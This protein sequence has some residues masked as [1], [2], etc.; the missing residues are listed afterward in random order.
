MDYNYYIFDLDGV[1]VDVTN[2]YKKEIMDKVGEKLN[3][4]F[5]E[6]QIKK[7]WYEI[8]GHRDSIIRSWGFN[9]EKFWNVFDSLDTP[10]KRIKNTFI[11][12]DTEAILK[13]K[14]KKMGVVT[15]SNFKVARETL[16]RNNIYRY[17]DTVI[18]CNQEIGY[19]PNPN[20]V[21]KCMERISAEQQKTVFVGDS[22]SDT[23]AASN[24]GI[25][26]CHI[27]RVDYML[28]SD[29]TIGSLHELIDGRNKS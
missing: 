13:L 1:L 10:Q 21:K 5:T 12:P 20:P 7:L 4:S 17:F 23:K 25:D 28:D 29:V 8:G 2:S 14:D 26:F 11:Y 16:K 22:V 27:N 24:V 3:Y 19:K 15:H 18:S 6:N 9:P